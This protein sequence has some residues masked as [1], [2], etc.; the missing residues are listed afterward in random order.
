MI[1]GIAAPDGRSSRAPRLLFAVGDDG[2]FLS[3][4]MAVARAALDAGFDVSVACPVAAH[5]DAIRARGVRVFPIPMTRGRVAPLADL[6]ALAALRRVYRAE[7][8]DL[9]HHVAM[10]PVI[11]GAAAARLAG[12]PASVG[13]LTGL[14]YV[15]SSSDARARALRPP[16]RR[17]LRWALGARGS[18]CLVQNP[19]DAAFVAGLGVD[20][21]RIA[22]IPGSGVDTVR[23]R[24]EPEPKGPVRAVMVSRMLWAKGVGEFVAAARL[25]RARAP[26]PRFVLVGE[27]DEGAPAAVPAARLEAWRDEG[28]VEWRGRSADVAAVWREAHIAVLPSRYGEGLPKSLLE[29]AACGRP[30]VAADAP[31]SREIARDG[32][33]ALL[34]PPR[35]PEALAGAILRL[36][37]DAALRAR[38]G[39][40]GRALAEREFSEA[41]VAE[42]TLALWRRLLAARDDVR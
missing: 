9:V 25:A 17:A 11:Y 27:P 37:G 12:I 36:A 41:R 21:R 2:F 14:G 31:G 39:A 8:P 35:D 32:E 22:T 38:L 42:A 34:V 19:D 23:F 7:R 18:F 29:A 30:I 10:K 4:R 40:A 28:V 24:P 6:R 16:L 5:G 33:T 26:E 13:A 3:H 1:D 15:F 20:P